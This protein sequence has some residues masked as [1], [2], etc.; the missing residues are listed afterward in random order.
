M[1]FLCVECGEMFDGEHANKRYESH[2]SQHMVNEKTD[3]GEHEILPI[4]YDDY[5]DYER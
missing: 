3:I 4:E 2:V 5:D 1:T